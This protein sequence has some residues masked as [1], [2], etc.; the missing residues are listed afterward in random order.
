MGRLMASSADSTVGEP[1]YLIPESI[2]SLLTV[3]DSLLLLLLLCADTDDTDSLS[4]V[5]TAVEL[6]GVPDVLE[7]HLL[8]YAL[9][10]RQTLFQRFRQ[11]NHN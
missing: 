6:V 8:K 5:V 1:S 3:D 7:P 10:P 9:L 11:K 4:G 2:D